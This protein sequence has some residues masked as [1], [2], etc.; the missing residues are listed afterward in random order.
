MLSTFLFS[1]PSSPPLAPLAP[2]RGFTKCFASCI[3]MWFIYLHTTWEYNYLQ[4]HPFLLLRHIHRTIVGAFEVYCPLSLAYMCAYIV[5]MTGTT[6]FCTQ[7]PKAD[8]CEAST[9][10]LKLIYP[11]R[12]GLSLNP[13]FNDLVRLANQRT[14]GSPEFFP[15]LPGYNRHLPLHLFL[16][17]C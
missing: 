15:P 3:C 8:F 14:Q 13:E 1:S 7:R 12:P 5:Y 6:H 2:L 4:F 16:T 10:G 11:L 9:I 17:G